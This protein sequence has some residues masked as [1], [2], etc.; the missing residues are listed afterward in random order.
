MRKVF[1]SF[2][3]ERDCWSVGQVRNSWL[4]NPHHDSQPFYDKA[5]WEQVKRSGDAAIKSWIDQNLKGTSVTVV[6]I[7]PQTL[8]RRWVKYEIDQT[9]QA[10][11]GL[12]GITL[13][14]V[15]QPDRLPDRW[16]RYTTYGP[17]DAK[18]PTHRIYS[19]T[20]HDGRRNLA[21]WIEDAAKSAAV[22]PRL[23]WI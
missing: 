2:H 7:G 15:I 17:F 4:A 23:T 9:L 6:L 5:R 19:W 21:T 8:G 16:N 18:A 22:Q 12:I 20:V 1:F 3:Y 10:K 14:N 13:E 11:K